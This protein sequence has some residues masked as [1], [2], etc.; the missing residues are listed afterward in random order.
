MTPAALS[1]LLLACLGRATGGDP[2]PEDRGARATLDALVAAPP[3]AATD[4][5]AAVRADDP[6]PTLAR[7]VAQ[8]EQAEQR[9]RRAAGRRVPTVADYPGTFALIDR[10]LVVLPESRAADRAWLAERRGQ[11]DLVVEDIV[12]ARRDFAA[13]SAALRG[14]GATPDRL[15]LSATLG[16]ADACLRL[17]DRAEA[18]RLYRLAFDWPPLTD[19]EAALQAR[20]LQRRAG[21]GLLDA[22]KAD[23]AA[24][25]ALQFPPTTDP[26]L[27]R[28]LQE[29]QAAARP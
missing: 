10:A 12:S 3:V 13:A 18:A 11:L 9:A 24:L 29:A 23:P 4:Y 19:A 16:E 26:G 6:L 28:R 2:M 20:E 25:L 21:Y 8:A 22:L 27:L 17:G 1:W 14:A 7:A 5:A 15:W